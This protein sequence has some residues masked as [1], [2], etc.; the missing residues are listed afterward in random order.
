MSLEWQT[1]GNSEK[2]VK[3]AFDAFGSG[4]DPTIEHTLLQIPECFGFKVPTRTSSEQYRAESFKNDQIWT[5]KL[6][7]V[8]VGDI[9]KVQLISPNGM[10][11]GVNSLPLMF[12][13]GRLY[14]ECIV[15]KDGPT[16]VERT[17]DSSRY[18]VLRIE[19]GRGNHAFLGLGFNERNEA[20]DFNVALED[21]KRYFFLY[22]EFVLLACL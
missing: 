15:R 2:S 3:M 1:D 4:A 16:V 22:Q 11:K 10:S 9:C 12:P 8:A 18:F 7:V 6:L 17:A 5:G 21:Q 20:F 13:Q 19:D 14:C